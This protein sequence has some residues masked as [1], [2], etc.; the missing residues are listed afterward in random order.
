VL[1]GLPGQHLLVG[2]LLI[3]VSGHLSCTMEMD[4]HPDDTEML[5]CHPGKGQVSGAGCLLGACSM[6]CHECVLGKQT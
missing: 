1:C 3:G 2:A 4:D 6:E 5:L